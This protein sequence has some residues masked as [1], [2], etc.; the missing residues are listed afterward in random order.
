MHHCL[1]WEGLQDVRKG[2][3][4]SWKEFRDPPEARDYGRGTGVGIAG[5]QIQETIQK[6]TTIII[7]IKKKHKRVIKRLTPGDGVGA[8]EG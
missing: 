6:K 5:A 7:I 4:L 3:E 1:E 8:G 2:A